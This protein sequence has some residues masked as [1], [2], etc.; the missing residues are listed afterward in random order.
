[1]SV[2]DYYKRFRNDLAKSSKQKRW[3][4]SRARIDASKWE[5][6][7]LWRRYVYTCLIDFILFYWSEK[8]ELLGAAG[9][10]IGPRSQHDPQRVR[11]KATNWIM[12][13][14]MNTNRVSCDVK[15]M[16][17]YTL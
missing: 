4:W 7:R 6:H 17:T 16:S 15:Y 9:F 12:R 8:L 13:V 14:N 5:K 2:V 1:M 3:V 11:C 10:Q